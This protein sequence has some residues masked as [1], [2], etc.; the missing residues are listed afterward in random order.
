MEFFLIRISTYLNWIRQNRDQKNSVFGQFSSSD[1]FFYKINFNAF[2]MWFWDSTFKQQITFIRMITLLLIAYK[3]IFWICKTFHPSLANDCTYLFPVY[4]NHP[5]WILSFWQ[6][7][8][9]F[10]DLK[11]LFTRK[12]VEHSRKMK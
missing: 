9:R 1:I 7:L 11:I 5:T 8:K 12:N 4:F 6:T 3:K 10:W 2:F